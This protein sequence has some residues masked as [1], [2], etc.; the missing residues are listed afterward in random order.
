MVRGMLD[1]DV[2]QRLDI[3]QYD[4]T[5]FTRLPLPRDPAIQL[6]AFLHKYDLQVKLCQFI[7]F[8]TVNYAP[9]R[10]LNPW[11]PDLLSQHLTQLVEVFQWKNHPELLSM[12]RPYPLYQEQFHFSSDEY[13]WLNNCLK[14]TI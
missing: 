11:L 2:N 13:H 4:M 7:N 12:T 9:Y 10:S 6:E 8:L 14:D 1:M 5:V 3:E